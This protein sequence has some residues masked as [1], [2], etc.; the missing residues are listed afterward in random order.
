MQDNE[1]ECV[2]YDHTSGKQY[3]SILAIAS[4]TGINNA[5]YYSTFNCNINC[6]GPIECYFN[7]GNKKQTLT[8]C[9]KE[10]LMYS[11]V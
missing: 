7:H 3:Y 8:C 11:S 1:M 9:S 2:V 6:K 4:M 10:R 5:F